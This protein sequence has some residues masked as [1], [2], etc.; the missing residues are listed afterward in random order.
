MENEVVSY[1]TL[2]MSTK[3]FARQFRTCFIKQNTSPA[4]RMVRWN[5]HGGNCMIQNGSSIGGPG[6]SGFGGLI[7][8]SYGVRVHGF[9]SNIRF[10]NILHAKLLAMYHGLVLAWELN[11]KEV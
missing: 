7:W 9:A 6:V 4:T 11:I 3:N 10:S 8:N 1:F 5:A 2:K